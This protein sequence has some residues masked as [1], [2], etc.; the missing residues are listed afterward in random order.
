[1]AEFTKNYGLTCPESTDYYNIEDQNGNMRIIDE[2]IS[3]TVNTGVYVGDGEVERKITLPRTPKFVLVLQN[4]YGLRNGDS[5]AH[6]F[7]GLAIAENPAHAGDDYI[8]I[9]EGGFRLRNLG[10]EGSSKVIR[11][12]INSTGVNYFYLWG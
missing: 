8:I 9:E 3:A 4:G 5:I 1:M 10:S 7:G 6:V 2:A 12:E 11:V